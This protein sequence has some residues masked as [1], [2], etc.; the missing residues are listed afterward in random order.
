ML[1]PDSLLVSCVA[2]TSPSECLHEVYSWVATTRVS[3]CDDL[4]ESQRFIADT[5]IYFDLQTVASDLYLIISNSKKAMGYCSAA[6]SPQ[7]ELV[8]AITA[9]AIPLRKN[10]LLSILSRIQ[11]TKKQKKLPIQ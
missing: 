5:E 8:G 11:I 2:D 9:T 4:F 7:P 6:S 1:H 3:R 10:I